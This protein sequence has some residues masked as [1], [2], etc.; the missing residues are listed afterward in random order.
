MRGIRLPAQLL[1]QLNL[2]LGDK[3]AIDVQQEKI[4][5]IPVRR[6]HK[7]ADPIAQCDLNAP[8]PADMAV[9]NQMEPQGR[10]L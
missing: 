2:T 4:L 9:W 7:L 5:L 3:L 6:P 10:E 8:M 1:R